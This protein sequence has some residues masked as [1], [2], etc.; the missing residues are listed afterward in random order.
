MVVWRASE[1]KVDGSNPPGV[2]N[3]LP[4][5]QFFHSIKF[6]SILTKKGA[7]ISDFHQIYTIDMFFEKNEKYAKKF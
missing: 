2:K 5:F 7:R 1:P 4:I 6:A 3:F